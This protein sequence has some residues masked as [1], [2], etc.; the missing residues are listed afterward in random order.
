MEPA[1]LCNYATFLFKHKRSPIRAREMFQKGMD[2]FPS[3]PGLNKNYKAFLKHEEKVATRRGNGKGRGKSESKSEGKSEGK[4]ENKDRD[5]SIGLQK[6]K[7]Q[8]H[9]DD[10][11]KANENDSISSIAPQLAKKHSQA[12][13]KVKL[14]V[15]LLV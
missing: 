13:L 8:Q 4:C 6:Q 12:S 3:H 11:G 2:K 15:L 9:Q 10:C 5:T 14:F 7:T 1:A